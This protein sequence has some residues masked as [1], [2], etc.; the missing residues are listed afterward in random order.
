MENACPLPVWKITMLHDYF[1]NDIFKI[2]TNDLSNSYKPRTIN[3]INKTT[4][5]PCIQF[6]VSSPFMYKTDIFSL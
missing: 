4:H 2:L 3:N 6:F 1:K 5:L